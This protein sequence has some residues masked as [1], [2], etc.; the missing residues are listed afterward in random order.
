MKKQASNC[1]VSRWDFVE[2][3]T[4]ANPALHHL[5]QIFIQINRWPCLILN[6]DR[7]KIYI[8]Y[9]QYM[10]LPICAFKDVTRKKMMNNTPWRLA[11]LEQHGRATNC[12][13]LFLSLPLSQVMQYAFFR[14]DIFSATFTEQSRSRAPM[15][16][17]TEANHFHITNSLSNLETHLSHQINSNHTH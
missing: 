4:T 15:S 2:L 14:C 9:I 12:Y 8:L 7:I 16:Q 13:K 3:E 17:Y 5:I 11:S 6:F 1:F 10:S